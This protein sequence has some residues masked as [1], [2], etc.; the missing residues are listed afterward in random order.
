MSVVTAD[1]KM[2]SF[3]SNPNNFSR[4]GDPFTT[5]PKSRIPTKQTYSPPH[6]TSPGGSSKWRTE[7]HSNSGDEGI[8]ECMISFDAKNHS[9]K[10]SV[11]EK[12]E[13]LASFNKWLETQSETSGRTQN[14]VM[15]QLQKLVQL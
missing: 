4:G 2:S 1:N 8:S 15:Y 12:T 11:C 5:P 13:L 10:W 6:K 14:A 9:K 7:R 3:F